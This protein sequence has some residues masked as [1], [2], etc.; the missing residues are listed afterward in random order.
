[1][2]NLK[3]K[4]AV[5]AIYVDPDFYPPTINAILNLSECFDEVIVVS[6]NN[7]AKDFPYPANVNL[8]KVGSNCTVRQMEKQSLWKKGFYFFKFC[9]SFLKYAGNI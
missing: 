2:D 5:V 3:F 9:L 4:R 7:A 1:M 8:K 6:R